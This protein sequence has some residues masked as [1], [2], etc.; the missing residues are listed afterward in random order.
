[1]L[2]FNYHAKLIDV[3]EEPLKKLLFDE[4]QQTVPKLELVPY[5]H[6]QLSVLKKE[7]QLQQNQASQNDALKKEYE[8]ELAALHKKFQ[9]KPP[10]AAASA[11]TNP[12]PSN[13]PQ[14]HQPTSAG[15][16]KTGLHQGG[17]ISN[18]GGKQKQAAAT[19]PST[20]WW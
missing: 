9:Q 16:E 15:D 3:K 8:D 10:P 5:P 18:Q 12:I 17:L 14:G 6:P 1:M 11:F 4:A 19:S 20:W 13:I 2:V 7:S